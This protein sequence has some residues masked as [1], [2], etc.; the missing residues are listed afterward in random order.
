MKPPTFY[1]YPMEDYD[2]KKTR[3]IVL[4]LLMTT[5]AVAAFRLIDLDIKQEWISLLASWVPSINRVAMHAEINHFSVQYLVGGFTM[6]PIVTAFSLWRLPIAY[7][8]CKPSV[9]KEQIWAGIIF[10]PACLFGSWIAI[11]VEGS[12][13]QVQ[14]LNSLLYGG[15]VSSLIFIGFL[16]GTQALFCSAMLGFLITKVSAQV[17]SRRK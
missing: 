15:E 5:G 11:G 8:M 13:R 3:Q 17:H 10:V 6:L 12:G 2:G 16:F 7:A 14:Y 1:G 9:R 4:L